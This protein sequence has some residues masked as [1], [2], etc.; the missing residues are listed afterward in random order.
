MDRIEP[1]QIKD[2]LSQNKKSRDWLAKECHVS[3]ST[4][5]GWIS[6]GRNIPPPSLS[7]LK[8]IMGMKNAIQPRLSLTTFLRAQDLATKRSM[9][10][11]QWLEW[12]IETHIQREIAAGTPITEAITDQD[13][14]KPLRV[15]EEPASN[16]SSR[17]GRAV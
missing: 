8:E 12:V 9:T 13:H 14:P 3:K 11:D 17:S 10:L 1:Q 15:A 16:K 6:A 7:I 4:V 2:W 5:D